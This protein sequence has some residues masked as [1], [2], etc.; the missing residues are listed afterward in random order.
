MCFGILRGGLQTKVD[1]GLCF[2]V[3]NFSTYTHFVYFTIPPLVLR[4]WKIS[5]TPKK[6]DLYGRGWS[7]SPLNI[8]FDASLYNTQMLHALLSSD[9]PW[10]SPQESFSIIGY[11]L[12]GSLVPTF[13]LS[14]PP[15]Q[16]ASIDSAILLAPAGLLQVARLAFLKKLGYRGWLPTALQTF[17][18]QRHMR[19]SVKELLEKQKPGDSDSSTM[20]VD[21]VTE[22]QARTH[23]GYLPAWIS[24]FQCCPIFDQHHIWSQFRTLAETNAFGALSERTQPNKV[25]IILAGKDDTVKFNEVVPAL[26][27]IFAQSIGDVDGQ[28]QKEA[29]VKWKVYENDGHDL[30]AT[31]GIDIADEILHFW[32]LK[33]P[34]EPM[35]QSWV[36][37]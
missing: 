22:W 21:S 24:S 12:G 37:A 31:K 13:L 34:R 8:R 28:T 6:I 7:D 4:F 9:L 2:S 30:V 1:V 27:Q 26:R 15:L 18:A 36:H 14:L 10:L 32:G 23:R 20:S 25:F 3:S 17:V 16:L 33:E 11:S 29:F 5:H 35:A 19:R